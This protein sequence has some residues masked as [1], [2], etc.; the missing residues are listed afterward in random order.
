MQFVGHRTPKSL[1]AWSA[2]ADRRQNSKYTLKRR[3]SCNPLRTP[4]LLLHKLQRSGFPIRTKLYEVQTSLPTSN[5]KRDR[6]GTRA[7]IL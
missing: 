5:I 4:P 6:S 1:R 7:L 2:V 3:P